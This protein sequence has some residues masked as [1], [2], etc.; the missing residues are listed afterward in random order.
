MPGQNITSLAFDLKDDHD[1]RDFIQIMM[2]RVGVTIQDIADDE[3][4]VR[5][6]VSTVIAGQ[7]KSSRIRA[8]VAQRIGIE[9]QILWAEEQRDPE[10]M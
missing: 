8:A 1:R 3:S 9:A 10:K 6:L 5:S 4:V 2:R 7:K